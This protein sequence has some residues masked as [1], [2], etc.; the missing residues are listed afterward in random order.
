MV[1]EVAGKTVTNHAMS[2]EYEGEETMISGA[3]RL[4]DKD[5]AAAIED[6]FAEG[7]AGARARERSAYDLMAG[8]EKDR[9][10][11]FGVGR[12]GRKTL[13]G[14]RKAGIEPI[15]FMDNNA[16]LWNTSV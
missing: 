8:A 13:S 14:L 11:L 9:I 2:S 12:L 10:V 5:F 3:N 1:A 7:E 16:R 4:T 6:L 15:A